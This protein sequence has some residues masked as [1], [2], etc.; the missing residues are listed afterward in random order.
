M[1]YQSAVWFM[2]NRWKKTKQFKDFEASVILLKRMKASDKFQTIL[3]S[4]DDMK[5]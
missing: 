4:F 1:S 3:Y 5:N 2:C